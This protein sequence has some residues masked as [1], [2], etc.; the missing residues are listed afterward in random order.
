D[1]WWGEFFSSVY[2][3]AVDAIMK[4]RGMLGIGD[5]DFIAAPDLDTTPKAY[6]DTSINLAGLDIKKAETK[7]KDIQKIMDEISSSNPYFDKSI[8]DN[9][10]AVNKLADAGAGSGKSLKDDKDAM[11]GT[12]KAAKENAKETEKAKDK[13]KDLDV[14]VETLTKTFQKQTFILKQHEER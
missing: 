13:I 1:G 9:V 7:T 10:D 6:S 4:V 8:R 2:G 14:E 12:S 3:K 11:N 5:D